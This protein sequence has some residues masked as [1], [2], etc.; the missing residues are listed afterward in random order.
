MEKD[1]SR[2]LLLGPLSDSHWPR[3]L[4]QTSCRSDTTLYPPLPTLPSTC[5]PCPRDSELDPEALRGASL[6]WGHTGCPV[7]RPSPGSVWWPLQSFPGAE[8]GACLRRGI[9]FRSLLWVP[10]GSQQLW[11]RDLLG[12]PQGCGAQCVVC[13]R[14]CREELQFPVPPPHLG[15][16]CELSPDLMASRPFPPSSVGTVLYSLGGGGFLLVSCVF[17]R[18]DPDMLLG[19]GEGM[20]SVSACP[21][22]APP[23][24]SVWHSLCTKCGSC[25]SSGRVGANFFYSFHESDF[26]GRAGVK[27]LPA[28]A[29]DVGWIPDPGRSSGKGNGSPLQYSCLQ[30]P[31][32][33]ETCGVTIHGVTKEG[34][35]LSN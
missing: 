20:I 5:G 27:N 32:D 25:D 13:T 10:L 34:S 11:G 29:V 24:D 21:P 19:G 16:S 8:A 31:I 9:R 35:W 12:S 33:R 3:C 28:N 15:P 6:G 4:V 14:L 18:C 23:Q 17:R 2:T 22:E 26:L 30:N 7:N 1:I